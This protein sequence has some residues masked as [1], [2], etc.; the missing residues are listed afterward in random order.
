[1]LLKMLVFGRSIGVYF[2]AVGG[3]TPKHWSRYPELLFYLAKKRFQIGRAEGCLHHELFRRRG[4]TF[5]V[6]MWEGPESFLAFAE[7]R[8]LGDFVRM[9]PRFSEIF[10][11]HYFRCDAAPSAAEAYRQWC[12]HQ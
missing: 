1:M 10:Y 6:S 4:V 9:A 7:G 2:A 5:V 11:F 3:I 8:A 12:R